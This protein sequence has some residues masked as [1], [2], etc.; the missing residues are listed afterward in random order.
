MVDADEMEEEME[1]GFGAGEDDELEVSGLRGCFGAGCCN[2]SVNVDV[3]STRI[4]TNVAFLRFCGYSRSSGTRV[5]TPCRTTLTRGTHAFVS[6]SAP[7]KTRRPTKSEQGACR[8]PHDHLVN[9]SLP[10]AGHQLSATDHE[11]PTNRPPPTV[12]TQGLPELLLLRVRQ[13]VHGM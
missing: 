6:L 3:T 1:E 9:Q 2:N 7:A 11:S 8:L 13:S 10:S 5:R 4:L 12:R